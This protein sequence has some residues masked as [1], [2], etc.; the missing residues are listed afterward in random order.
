MEVKLNR[1]L[2]VEDNEND[3]ELTLDALKD[4]KIINIIDVVRDGAEALDYLYYKGKYS[5][6]KNENPALVMLDLNLP[7]IGGLDVLRQIKKDKNLNLIP[8]VILTSSKE[9]HD[10]IE[11]YRLGTNAYVVKPV[12]FDAFIEA[13]KYLG[14]FWGLI[15]EPPL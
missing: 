7:K 6:R 5:T 1:I 8:V 2:L 3:L 15:N 10:I 12:E 9:E 4:N 11:S 13:V 14:A